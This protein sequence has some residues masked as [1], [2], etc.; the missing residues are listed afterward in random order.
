MAIMADKRDYYE[1]LG[2]SRNANSDEIKKAYRK[3][4]MKYHPDRNSSDKNAED[5]FKEATEAY[6]I[7]SNPEK[8]S[9]YDQFGHAGVGAGGFGDA[10]F[11]DF[12]DLFGG[13]GDI[14][15][16]I[17]GGGRSRRRSTSRHR[18]GNDLRYDLEISL[19]EA[20][21]GVEKP[22]Q[23]PKLINCDACGGSGCVP[24]HQPETC[25]QCNGSGQVR[26]AQGFFSISRTCNHC[27][28]T[29]QIIKN[30][31]V[32]CHGSGRAKSSSR[33]SVRIPP[34]AMTGLKL[35]V[36][37][38]GESGFNGGPPGDLYIVLIVQDHPVFQRE[39]DDVICE[40]PISFPQAALGAE[41]KVPTLSGSVNMKLPAGTQTGKL[42]R[43]SGKG[44]PSLR[45]YG[46]GDQLVRVVVETPTRLTARQRELLEEFAA[47]SGE[48]TN[49]QSQSF[50]ERVKQVFG[51]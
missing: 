40:V 38:E 2:V 45:G 42:F 28:G 46:H 36:T 1:V 20:Y 9:Q 3:L 29:G 24:G 15:E 35:K 17:F 6:E 11:H 39:D 5:K 41:I 22:I 18:R 16:E 33:V 31:C 37:G 25:P 10:A 4:A 43:L 7:L 12:Q 26:L 48:D 21:R 13:F 23:V 14:F 32:K 49:P 8:R 51:G 27:G 47:V 19:E 50:F 44:M 34:G 30:P